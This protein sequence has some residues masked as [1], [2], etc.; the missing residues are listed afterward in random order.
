MDRIEPGSF[1]GL[2]DD[3]RRKRKKTDSVSSSEK[4]GFSQMLRPEMVDSVDEITRS[5]LRS[6]RSARG[7]AEAEELL[8][9]IH[10]LGE[11][12]VRANTLVNLDRYREAIQAFLRIVVSDGLE[13]Q[14]TESGAN[15]MNRKRFTTVAVVDQKL[16]RLAGALMATQ[17]EPLAL[18][19]RV[20]EIEGLLVNLLQ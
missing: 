10:V 19:A 20:Q 17:A 6:E 4:G 7:R 3:E 11:E 1:F 9:T 18:L 5:G 12:L 15:V 8:D 16:D 2:R 13:V 14:E